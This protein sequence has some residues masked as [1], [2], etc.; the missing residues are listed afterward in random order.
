MKTIEESLQYAHLPEGGFTGHITFV[1]DTYADFLGWKE[2]Y[3][4]HLDAATNMF[5]VVHNIDVILPSSGN[6]EEELNDL[7]ETVGGDAYLIPSQYQ[8]QIVW[9][10]DN[11]K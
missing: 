11:I 8:G 4:D 10:F 5:C 6:L 9:A 3:G 1:D 2:E 7:I